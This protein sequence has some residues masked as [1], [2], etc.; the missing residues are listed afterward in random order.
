MRDSYRKTDSEFGSIGTTAGLVAGGFSSFFFGAIVG[1]G[2]M[3]LFD[4]QRGTERRSLIRD[5]A[6]NRWDDVSKYATRAGREIRKRAGSVSHPA[7]SHMDKETDT[8]GIG[9]TSSKNM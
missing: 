2:L 4:P 6:R 5:Q 9:S 8:L 3:Y 7:Q 1:A